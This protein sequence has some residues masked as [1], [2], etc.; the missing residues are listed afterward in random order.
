[1]RPALKPSS[2]ALEARRIQHAG[3]NS[4][5]SRGPLFTPGPRIAG[6]AVRN[7]SPG[8]TS[9]VAE[10]L[11][12]GLAERE[13]EHALRETRRLERQ[14]SLADAAMLA[15]T[16]LFVDE[17][18]DRIAREEFDD[19][20]QLALRSSRLIGRV[21]DGIDTQGPARDLIA[22][23][24]EK[25][26]RNVVETVGHRNRE[27]AEAEHNAV[28]AD[29]QAR[30]LSQSIALARAAGRAGDDPFARALALGSMS[31]HRAKAF[32]AI[33]SRTDLTPEVKLAAKIEIE[34]GLAEQA[35]RGGFDAAANTSILDAAA[36][37]EH[38]QARTNVPIDLSEDA[39]STLAGELA[40][41]TLQ[42]SDAFEKRE[43]LSD[44]DVRRRASVLNRQIQMSVLDGRKPPPRRDGMSPFPGL[45]DVATIRALEGWRGLESAGTDDPLVIQA[46][47]RRIDT[48]SAVGRN[49]GWNL[50]RDA[51]VAGALTRKSR[52]VFFALTAEP[53][54]DPE[55]PLNTETF[56]RADAEVAS[57]LTAVGIPVEGARQELASRSL[58]AD[59]TD[60]SF[61]SDMKM[62]QDDITGRWMASGRNAAWP[63]RPKFFE[64]TWADGEV[65][66]EQ[67]RDATGR[68]V[69][70]ARDGAI[71]E[72]RLWREVDRLMSA[73]RIMGERRVG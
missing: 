7:G 29:F 71:P 8:A 1:M 49:A 22:A 60:L 61:E 57:S 25:R 36:F 54:D 34:H 46:V 62:I 64:G 5:P 9:A 4:P 15:R 65:T 58:G 67:L 38:L 72:A 50:A 45:S 43:R 16:S 11:A 6:A 24:F 32:L 10:R 44:I 27:Q 33:D 26:R 47:Y 23:D 56:R 18:L 19:P 73:R 70:A 28:L 52:D 55:S 37:V 3:G 66:M 35:V 31:E 2:T 13:R 20:E 42:L 12:N 69:R 63:V 17:G 41:E 39:R 21:L 40:N 53:G 48:G 59:P 30:A 51:H 68:T 14:R